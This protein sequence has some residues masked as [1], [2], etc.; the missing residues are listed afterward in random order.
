[1]KHNI[2]NNNSWNERV[3]F[4]TRAVSEHPAAEPVSL[5]PAGLEPIGAGVYKDMRRKRCANGRVS[6]FLRGT[7]LLYHR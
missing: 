5:R 2:E 6:P 3:E 4:E 7:V 1:M